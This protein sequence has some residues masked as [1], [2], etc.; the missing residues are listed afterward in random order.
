MCKPYVTGP[1]PFVCPGNNE[2]LVFT[3]RESQVLYLTWSFQPNYTRDPRNRFTYSPATTIGKEFV[4]GP[5]TTILVDTFNVSNSTSPKV[6]DMVSTV[7]VSTKR[8]L[9][10]TT[11]TCIT[12]QNIHQSELNMSITLILAGICTYRV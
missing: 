5:F 12:R 9:N 10:E 2:T 8:L 1:T 3:C 4:S 7:E 11:I 6:S